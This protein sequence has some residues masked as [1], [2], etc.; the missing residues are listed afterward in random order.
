MET[1]NLSTEAAS[2]QN[3]LECACSWQRAKECW[4][5][6]LKRLDAR[7]REKPRHYFL[8]ALAAGYVL[9]VIPWRAL[10][11]LLGILFVR[12]LRPILLFIAVI[13]LAEFLEKKSSTNAAPQP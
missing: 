1:A 9:H 13:K 3:S 12:L 5:E 6:G 2:G 7:I 8:G 10:F 4:N 11:F